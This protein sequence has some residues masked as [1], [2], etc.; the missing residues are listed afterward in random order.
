MNWDQDQNG[1]QLELN[2]PGSTLEIRLLSEFQLLRSLETRPSQGWLFWLYFEPVSVTA[3]WWI[4]FLFFFFFQFKLSKW[5][6]F[7]LQPNQ[8]TTTNKT[9]YKLLFCWH[10]LSS[11]NILSSFNSPPKYCALSLNTFWRYTS[12]LYDTSYSNF[13]SSYFIPTSLKVSDTKG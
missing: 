3:S 8:P 11:S 6:F 13:W 12:T 7:F 10:L 2:H 9:L 5:N 4:P 1:R